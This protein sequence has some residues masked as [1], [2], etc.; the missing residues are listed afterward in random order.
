MEL[1]KM[2]R[3]LA[4]GFNSE[5]SIQLPRLFGMIKW[6]IPKNQK[7]YRKFE[8]NSLISPM[9]FIQ[10]NIVLGEKKDTLHCVQ[11]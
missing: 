3:I 9:Y 8:R 6:E 7:F 10:K 5:S 4:L 1:L 11:S 2:A